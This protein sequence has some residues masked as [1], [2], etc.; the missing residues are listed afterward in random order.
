MI[1]VKCAYCGLIF[2]AATVRRVYCSD[3]CRRKAFREKQN[4][5]KPKPKQ[6]QSEPAPARRFVSADDPA[7]GLIE[8]MRKHGKFSSEWWEALQAYELSRP[9]GGSLTVNGIPV[10]IADFPEVMTL[11]EVD[12]YIFLS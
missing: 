7:N 1:K 10:D 3:A 6:I 2:E 9:G 11:L 12:R 4:K 8:A 5:D